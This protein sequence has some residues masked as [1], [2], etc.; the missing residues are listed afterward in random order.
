MAAAPPGLQGLQLLQQFTAGPAIATSMQL[1]GVAQG[2][3]DVDVIEIMPVLL[4]EG[5]QIV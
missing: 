1:V 2:C 4:Y 5:V 3:G